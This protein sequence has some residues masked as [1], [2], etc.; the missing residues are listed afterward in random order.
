MN[1]QCTVLVC[2]CDKYEDAWDPFFKL[3]TIQWPQLD[4]P[5][6][7]NTESKTYAFPGLDIKTFSLFPNPDK[8]M[9]GERLIRHLQ[10][11]KTEYVLMMMDDFF[12]C[13][14]VQH[15][16]VLQTIKAMEENPDVACM[17]FFYA[18]F[19]PKE[20]DIVDYRFPN[21]VRR[22][23]FAP[24]KYNC[25][26]ALWRRKELLTF[27]RP[28]ESPWVWET[29]GNMRSWRSKQTF[30]CAQK[31]S[32]LVFDYFGEFRWSGIM[33]GR[34]YINYVQ[35]LFEKYGILVDFEARGV[36]GDDEVNAV[37]NRKAQHP[38][39]HWYKEIGG[40]IKTLL[41]NWKSLM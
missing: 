2:S 27:I 24:Y 41:V 37:I 21:M 3:L 10:K 25:Q 12:L 17:S 11:I 6:V 35:P 26:V 29:V 34:W 9:W 38:F 40:F 15:D 23:R 33:R 7:L 30:Y 20:H 36:I 13:K 14:P 28:Q 16:R 8:V 5:I 39:I 18:D 22:K 1:T 4:F 32:D 31:G 19:E